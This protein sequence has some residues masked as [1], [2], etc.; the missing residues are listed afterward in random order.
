[1]SHKQRRRK[2]HDG[3][4]L[5][6]KSRNG[7]RNEERRGE[8]RRGEGRRGE[9]RRGE[10]RR[11]E[12]RR[13]SYLSLPLLPSLTVSKPTAAQA[14]KFWIAPWSEVDGTEAGW[15]CKPGEPQGQD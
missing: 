2:K 6:V 9:G 5:R 1:M 14:T 12:E 13:F 3:R 15:A 11:G 8:G 10:G 7:W 4:A